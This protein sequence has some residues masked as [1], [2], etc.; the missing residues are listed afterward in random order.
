MTEQSKKLEDL[1]MKPELEDEIRSFQATEGVVQTGVREVEQAKK[2]IKINYDAWD[3]FSKLFLRI[4][5]AIAIFTLLY[6]QNYWILKEWLFAKS[7][8]ELSQAQ[9]AVTAI[10]AAT[11][12]ETYLL[13]RIVVEYLFPK[14]G[15]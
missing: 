7:I 6:L 4:V 8:T 5:V 9:G 10:I 15:K 11:L 12:G 2:E 1:K 14:N 3:F 13:G